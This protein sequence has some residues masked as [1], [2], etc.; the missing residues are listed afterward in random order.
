MTAVND[1]WRLKVSKY[2]GDK[3]TGA[4]I[5]LLDHDR[6]SVVFYF[7]MFSLPPC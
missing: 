2:T 3:I 7:N 4:V 5:L 1:K 6:L